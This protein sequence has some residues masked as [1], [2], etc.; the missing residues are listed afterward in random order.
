MLGACVRLGHNHRLESVAGAGIAHPRR[1]QQ[2]S[3]GNRDQ[4]GGV[5]GNSLLW[6]ARRCRG[7]ADHGEDDQ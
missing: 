6:H 7:D 2:R 4:G 5:S 1:D 3:L